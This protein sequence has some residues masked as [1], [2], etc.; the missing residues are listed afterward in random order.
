MRRCTRCGYVKGLP[1]FRR[2]K[3][4]RNA[5]AKCGTCRHCR[6]HSPLR[7]YLNGQ[8]HAHRV[9]SHAI[10]AGRIVR[11]SRCSMCGVPNRRRKLIAHH[12]SGYHRPLAVIWLCGPCHYRVHNWRSEDGFALSEQW[13]GGRLVASFWYGRN[14]RL[15]S[16]VW[17]DTDAI[18][19]LRFGHPALVTKVKLGEY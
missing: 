19:A 5:P 8:K 6:G 12:H 2:H 18:G 11:R 13:S 15:V 10:R 14:G 16:E 17:W 4:P 9:V 3:S 1:E 7:Q